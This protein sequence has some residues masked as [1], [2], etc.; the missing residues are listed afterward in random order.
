MKR[1][2]GYKEVLLGLE[3]KILGMQLF[4]RLESNGGFCRGLLR[5]I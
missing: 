5:S 1:D 2:E 3:P 4:R